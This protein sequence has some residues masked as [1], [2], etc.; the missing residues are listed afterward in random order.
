MPSSPARPLP[1]SRRHFPLV[2]IC[3][4]LTPSAC[5]PELGIRS[6]MPNNDALQPPRQFTPH[7]YAR[8]E[9]GYHHTKCV[10]ASWTTLYPALTA[11][12]QSTLVHS[13]VVTGSGGLPLFVASAASATSRLARTQTLFQGHAIG[14]LSNPDGLCYARPKNVRSDIGKSCIRSGTIEKDSRRPS[15]GTFIVDRI[16]LDFDIGERL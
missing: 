9:L 13:A 7:V 8:E 15:G 12:P 5:V 10:D 11:V 4:I 1:R 3:A 6:V 16:G 14:E 2:C